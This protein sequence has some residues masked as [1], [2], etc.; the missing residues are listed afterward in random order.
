MMKTHTVTIS[1]L[2][3]M[4]NPT[5]NISK[6]DLDQFISNMNFESTNAPTDAP[7]EYHGL[8]ICDLNGDARYA[9]FTQPDQSGGNSILLLDYED[10]AKNWQTSTNVDGYIREIKYLFN[11][12]I[13]TQLNTE[14]TCN[15]KVAQPEIVP[16]YHTESGYWNWSPMYI[17]QFN[18]TRVNNCYNYAV[19]LRTNTFAQVGRASGY[20]IDLSSREAF[21][22]S[23]FNGARADGLTYPAVIHEIDITTSFNSLVALITAET[24]SGYDFHWAKLSYDDLID[25][26]AFIWSHKA[27][28]TNATHLGEEFQIFEDFDKALTDALPTLRGYRNTKIVAYLL[29]DARYA[30]IN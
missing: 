5:E 15:S 7:N 20:P 8:T 11:I 19:S 3:G 26:N 18:I 10:S 28:Q 24:D 29:V 1:V 4:P 14:S 16:P 12:D 22:L 17:N 23:V 21:D 27:G 25:P 30:R 9:L 2:S 6:A 13:S